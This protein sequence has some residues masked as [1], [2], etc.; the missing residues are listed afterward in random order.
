VPDS[1]A[2]GQLKN[3]DYCPALTR[4]TGAAWAMPP[5]LESVRLG[6][7]GMSPEKLSS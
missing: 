1:G 4:L 7:C 2:L 6:R 5:G 3:D